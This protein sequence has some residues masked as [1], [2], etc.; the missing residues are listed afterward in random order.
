MS[1]DAQP[2][3]RISEILYHLRHL[4]EQSGEL[5]ELASLLAAAKGPEERA[6][7]LS[8]IEIATLYHL[9]YHLKYLRVPLAR[10]LKRAYEGLGE[11]EVV[12]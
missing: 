4:A 7:L 3:D 12:E 8:R 2:E 6:P 5:S 11:D 9:G 10:E 1:A